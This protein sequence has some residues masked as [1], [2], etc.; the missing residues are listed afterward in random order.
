MKRTKT[1]IALGLFLALGLSL[2]ACDNIASVISR[3]GFGK[4]DGVAYM[5]GQMDALYLGEFDPEYLKMIDMEQTEAQESYDENLD[6]RVDDFI[7]G[8]S[9]EY[10]TDAFKDRVKDLYKQIYAKAD[11]TVVSSAEQDDG[12]YSVKITIRPLD[13]MQL[14]FEEL[15][16]FSQQFEA[17]YADVDV[18][19]MTEEEYKTWNETVYDLDYQNGLADLLESVIAKMGTLEE[20]SIAVQIEKDPDDGFYVI[21]TESIGNLDALI[22]DF[23]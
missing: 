13:V 8:F 14:F 9:I 22:I 18:E 12:S 2:T 4:I 19:S 6:F 21:N 23:S 5:Q 20:K 7:Q 10:P 16:D 15:P 3:G 1:L 17:K 11:Y